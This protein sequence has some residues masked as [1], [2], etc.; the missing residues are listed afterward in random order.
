MKFTSWTPP[1]RPSTTTASSV[2]GPRFRYFFFFTPSSFL[3]LLFHSIFPSPLFRAAEIRSPSLDVTFF[4]GSSVNY[5][6]SFPKTKSRPVKKS[7]GQGRV[8]R[9]LRQ[10]PPSYSPSVWFFGRATDPICQALCSEMLDVKPYIGSEDHVGRP[11]PITNFPML[12]TSGIVSRQRP[13]FS[14]SINPFVS[15]LI[16][17]ESTYKSAWTSPTA[18][19]ASGKFNL[20]S[21]PCL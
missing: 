2:F 7:E 19:Q 21:K 1:A 20:N 14:L 13:F 11:A 8:V 4:P 5:Y 15:Y 16:S 3:Y 6:S 12:L 17:A 18:S 10:I 9:W